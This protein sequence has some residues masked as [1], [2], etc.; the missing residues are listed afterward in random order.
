MMR[1]LPPDAPPG[2]RGA[3]FLPPDSDPYWDRHAPA[4][5]VDYFAGVDLAQLQDYSALAVVRR[6]THCKDDRPSSFEVPALKRWPIGTPYPKIVADVVKVVTT[7]ETAGARLAVDAT[8]VGR[9]VVDLLRDAGITL[10]AVTITA[11]RGTSYSNGEV[12]VSKLHLVGLIQSLLGSGRLKVAKGGPLGEVLVQE[13]RNF[14][15]RVGA[16]GAETFAAWREADHAALLL[17]PAD[18]LWRAHRGPARRG[19]GGP[20]QLTAPL[21]GLR[22]EDPWWTA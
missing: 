6:V 11:G 4:L 1:D 15:V 18:G 21:G 22:Q 17:A 19:P 10:T 14:R 8:G 3:C 9:P 12:H 7:G 2:L 13:A 16:T 5:L 20:V